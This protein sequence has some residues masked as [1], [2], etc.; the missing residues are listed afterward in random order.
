MAED[1]ISLIVISAALG[2][3]GLVLSKLAENLTD[4]P[5]LFVMG[6]AHVNIMTRVKDMPVVETASK[7]M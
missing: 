4:R 2:A 7:P 6:H 3:V 1:F 5:D